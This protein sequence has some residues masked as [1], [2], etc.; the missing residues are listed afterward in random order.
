MYAQIRT[1]WL[2]LQSQ[3]NPG[4]ISTG[5]ISYEVLALLSTLSSVVPTGNT[6]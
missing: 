3:E 6:I 1:S 4:E 5:S 2:T